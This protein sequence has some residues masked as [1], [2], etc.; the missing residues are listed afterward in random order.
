MSDTEQGKSEQPTPF[1]LDQARKKGTIAR[2]MDLAFLGSLGA[3]LLYGW[4]AGDGLGRDISAASRGTI[5]IAPTVLG[6]PDELFTLTG[7]IFAAVARPLAF[8]AVTVF[9]IVLLLE[10]LQTGFVFTAAPL[11]PDFSRLNPAKGLKRLFSVRL[12]IETAKNVL[13]LAAYGAVTWLIIRGALRSDAAAV[14]DAAGLAAALAGAGLRLIA[15]FVGVAVLFAA[16]DQIVVR[17]DFLKKMRMSRRDIRREARDREGEP[18]MK[19]RR[20]QLHGEFVKASQSLRGVRNADV[21]VTNPTHF[22]VALHYDA[23]KMT[24]PTVVARGSNALALRIK[25]LAFLYGSAIV[26]DKALA[27]AL[28]AGCEIGSQVPELFYRQVADVYLAVRARQEA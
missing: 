8:L 3:L 12:L 27:R 2:G 15:C 21:V 14:G 24:A 23:S 20:K 17:K 22:A 28:Y 9:A 26:E 19:Q 11:K 25:R 10:L 1:K 13:K 6:S 4:F 18:R 5:V 16:F 7:E